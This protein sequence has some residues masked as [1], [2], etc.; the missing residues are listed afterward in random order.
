[1]RPRPPLPPPAQNLIRHM[2][3]DV[4]RCQNQSPRKNGISQT[5]SPTAIV[6]GHAR[7]DYNTMKIK[8]GAYAQVFDDHYPT[9]TPAARSIGAIAL[10]PTGN[11]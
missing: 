7:P 6:T 3:A 10:D 11:V 4:T 1:M 5:L 8:F 2:V 9:N